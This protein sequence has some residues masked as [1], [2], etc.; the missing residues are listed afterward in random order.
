MNIYYHTLDNGLRLVH[1][2]TTNQVAWCGLA[3]NAGSR[4]EQ[5]HFPICLF[6]TLHHFAHGRILTVL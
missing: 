5:V 1:V 3:V 6:F 4:D 2:R